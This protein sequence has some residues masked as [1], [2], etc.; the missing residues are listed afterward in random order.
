MFDM[1]NFRFY[2]LLYYIY[3]TYDVQRFKNHSKPMKSKDEELVMKEV[4]DFFLQGVSGEG[5]SKNI[6]AVV[7]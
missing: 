2:I 3:I 6:K 5:A 7:S 1:R 4:N